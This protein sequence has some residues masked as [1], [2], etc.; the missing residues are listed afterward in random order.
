MDEAYAT[1]LAI[2]ES[3]SPELHKL[4]ATL[5]GKIHHLLTSVSIFSI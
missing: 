1:L 5:N 3:Q 4:S 2:S